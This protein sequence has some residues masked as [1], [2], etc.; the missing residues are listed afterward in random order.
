MTYRWR[1]TACLVLWASTAS[2]VA[3]GELSVSPKCLEAVGSQ[4]GVAHRVL[5]ASV[6]EVRLDRPRIVPGIR[7]R[8]AGPMPQHMGVDFQPEIRRCRRP[9]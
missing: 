7:Q 6:P 2:T 8:K 9:L 3:P 1:G 4:L 5:D